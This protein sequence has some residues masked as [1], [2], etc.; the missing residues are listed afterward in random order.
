MTRTRSDRPR[1]ALPATIVCAALVVAL[2]VATWYVTVSYDLFTDAARGPMLRGAI[3]WWLLFGAAALVVRFVPRRTA[4]I[5]IIAG[6]AAIS[7]AA[8]AAPPNT[9]T[10]SARYAWD[11]IVQN[12]GVSPYA[13][14]PASST[15]EHL[16]TDWLFPPRID[17]GCPQERTDAVVLRPGQEK[18]CTTINRPHVP[19]IY[20]AAAELYFAGVRFLVPTSAAYWPLQLAG[21]LIGVGTTVLLV[22]G[23]RRNGVDP[24]WASLW[25]WCPLVASEVVTNSHVD[26]LGALLVTA[27]SLLVAR[28]TRWRGGIAL[29][30]AIA[31]KLIPAIAVPPLLRREGWKVAVA[32]VATFLVLY[33]PY[34]LASGTKVI[35]YLPGYL[36]EEGYENGSRFALLSSWLPGSTASIVGV[37]VIAIIAVLCFLRADPLRP[38]RT[39]VILV[40]A[41]LVIA[42]PRYDWYALLLVPFA[43]LAA[44]P[45]WLA[46]AATL[47]YRLIDYHITH[48][49]VALL[50]AIIVIL[51]TTAWRH[52]DRLTPAS[53]KRSALGVRAAFVRT[54]APYQD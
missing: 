4:V 22:L 25:A 2:I 19:T 20:P 32:A 38:W 43:V 16:H 33:V 35:G 8:L 13:H 49:R 12:A 46:V 47:A 52:R 30:A 1:L 11:G 26:A 42:S 53:L 28:G 29:G 34:V 9:S 17:G 54:T 3:V 10:D 27:G 37:L 48:F 5:L 31:V 39:Q 21:A 23:L 15:L 18:A 41:V 6:S 50:I 36:S 24:R 14:P 51:A 45:E 40:G 44:R 7:G